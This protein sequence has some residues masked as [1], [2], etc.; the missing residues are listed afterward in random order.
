M[1]TLDIKVDRTGLIAI[2]RLL[3]TIFAILCPIAMIIAAVIVTLNEGDWWFNLFLVY[4][5]AMVMIAGTL[6]LSLITLMREIARLSDNKKSDTPTTKLIHRLLLGVSIA[7]II[8]FIPF[9]M[10]FLDILNG[11]FAIL[12]F[13]CAVVI[14]LLY[15]VNG[16]LAIKNR[17]S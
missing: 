10:I 8:T 12:H 6:Y 1:K 4:L 14:L 17:K 9:I 2:L 13:I 7:G 3:T 11:G 16:I 5:G 15:L